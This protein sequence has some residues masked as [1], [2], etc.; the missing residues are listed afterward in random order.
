M[1][2][3]DPN[4]FICVARGIG[5]RLTGELHCQEMYEGFMAFKAIFG[6]SPETAAY[7]YAFGEL[8]NK[9]VSVSHFLWASAFAK[10]YSNEITI[11]ASFEVTRKTF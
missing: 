3:Y 4:H 2:H 9:K 8:K 5:Y 7:V 1:L 6:L 11:S 10:E